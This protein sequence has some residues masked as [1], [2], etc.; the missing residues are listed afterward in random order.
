MQDLP[1]LGASTL[2]T[3][4]SAVNGAGTIVGNAEAPAGGAIRPVAW[5]AGKISDLGTLGGDSGYTEAV[6]ELGNIVGMSQTGTGTYHAT[7]WTVDGVIVDLDTRSVV[8]R[9]SR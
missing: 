7:L 8:R 9:V 5:L 2:Y 6:N 4:A 1:T 3:H